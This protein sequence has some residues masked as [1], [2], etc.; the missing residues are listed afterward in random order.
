MGPGRVAGLIGAAAFM[1]SAGY[2]VTFM[3]GNTERAVLGYFRNDPAR[4]VRGIADPAFV[5]GV[6]V[7]SLSG[8]ACGRGT[9]MAHSLTALSLGAATVLDVIHGGWENSSSLSRQSFSS[10]SALG[11]QH[12]I[13]EGWRGISTAEL[14]DRDPGEDGPGHRTPH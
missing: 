4:D 10:P 12:V 2:F 1:H 6:V 14:C 9:R 7:A 13:H 8:G 11:A 5:G 3:T